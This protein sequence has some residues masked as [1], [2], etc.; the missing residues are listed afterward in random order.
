MTTVYRNLSD[1][2]LTLLLKEADE[3]A[4][5]EIYNRHWKL[6]YVHVYKMLRDEDEAKDVVQVV[7]GNL[8]IKAASI[9]NNLNI[10]GLLYTSARNKVFDL[11]EKNKVRNDYIGEIAVFMSDHANEKVDT[12]DEKR[13]LQI[14]EREIQK[15]PPKMKEIFELSRKENLS[16][17]EIAAR[18]NISEQTV[19]KQVQNALKVIKPK[20]NDL[21]LSIAVLLLMR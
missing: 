21:G 9:K 10:S 18:L 11:I 6:I 12:I 3:V 20:L 2:E 4:F 14:L 15:L 17:K 7:F 8:W 19:K 13:I 16:H 1:A 5:T